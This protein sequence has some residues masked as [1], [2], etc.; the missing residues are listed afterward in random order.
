MKK[1]SIETIQDG[2]IELCR[3]LC[4]ELMAFQKSK[5]QLHPEWFDFM[6]FDTRMKKSHEHALRSQVV[7][8]KDNGTPVGYVF[9]TIDNVDI[10]ERTSYPDW[11]PADKNSLG[12]YP[13]WV[14]LPQKTGCLSNLYLRNEYRS[15]GLG[16]KLFNT[17]MEWLESFPDVNLTF[18]YI[19]NGNDAALKFYLEHGFTFSHDVF[20]GFITAACRVKNPAS[21]PGAD[22][23]PGA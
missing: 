19:S 17:A 12:F 5:A 22:K 6:N 3:E 9:S 7:V 10:S 14:T 15:S 21:Y 4:D 2:N 18:V 16:L 13:E 8:I 11:A 20:G 1:I 23:T